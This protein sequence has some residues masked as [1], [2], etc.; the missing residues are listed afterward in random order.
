LVLLP[1]PGDQ[2]LKLVERC[3]IRIGYEI[4]KRGQQTPARRGTHSPGAIDHLTDDE[5][6]AVDSRLVAIGMRDF[7]APDEP[8]AVQTLER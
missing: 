1:F 4:Q 7:P 3:F 6:L 8:F 2:I 5:V